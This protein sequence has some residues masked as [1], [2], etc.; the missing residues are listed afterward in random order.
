MYCCWH[1]CKPC[2]RGPGTELTLF[3]SH[4]DQEAKAGTTLIVVRA[5]A[6]VDVHATRIS[7]WGGST[8]LLAALAEFPALFEVVAHEQVG[9]AAA[10]L[11]CLNVELRLQ[12]RS[13]CL[14]IER[15]D[16]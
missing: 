9:S 16:R 10:D 1:A 4:A 2:K 7:A 3:D 8:M 12:T 6:T 11:T 13:D 14:F 5:S 15:H